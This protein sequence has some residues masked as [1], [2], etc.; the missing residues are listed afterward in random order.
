MDISALIDFPDVYY[1]S[2]V[3][4]IYSNLHVD[5]DGEYVSRVRDQR[6][7]LNPMVLNGML[8]FK[9]LT[10]DLV[11]PLTKNGFCLMFDDLTELDQ[12]CLVCGDPTNI[13]LS[14]SVLDPMAHLIF[15][16]FQTNICPR[17]GSRPVLTCQDLIMVPLLPKGKRF[18]ISGLILRNI[19]DFLKKK[20]RALL[21]GPLL[22]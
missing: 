16:I 2:L 7:C 20:Q 18:D 10:D 14:L 21:Y 3:Q 6:M 15:K 17:V 13:N 11:V 8:K 9:G 4:E 1:P 19:V 12:L 5:K 22:T